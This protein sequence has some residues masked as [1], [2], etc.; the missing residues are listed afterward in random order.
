VCTEQLTEQVVGR[1]L[2]RDFIGAVAARPWG[3]PYAR[4]SQGCR[5]FFRDLSDFM[6]ETNMAYKV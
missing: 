2:M 1:R 5:L 4:S 6:C 3:Q